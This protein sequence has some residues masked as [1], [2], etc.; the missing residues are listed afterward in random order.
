VLPVVFVS[1]GCR[2]SERAMAAALDSRGNGPGKLVAAW[3]GPNLSRF[4]EHTFLALHQVTW[5]AG[6]Y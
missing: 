5:C 1:V 2:P 6:S 4:S 3:N